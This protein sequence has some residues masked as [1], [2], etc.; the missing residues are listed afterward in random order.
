[1]VGM[2]ND[3]GSIV[4]DGMDGL[5]GLIHGDADGDV[6]MMESD[7]GG[8][9]AARR[10]SLPSIRTD[11]TQQ[12][13][14]PITPASGVSTAYTP[15][16]GVHHANTYPPIGHQQS[17][18]SPAGLLKVQESPKEQNIAPTANMQPPGNDGVSHEYVRGL[19]VRIKQLESTVEELR[20]ELA[21]TRAAEETTAS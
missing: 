20:R 13:G 16:P 6:D 19:E 10:R 21:S 12:G 17:R 8:N 11:F 7:S 14:N 15:T 9:G 1:M 3:D 4:E 5:E 2:I 18:A